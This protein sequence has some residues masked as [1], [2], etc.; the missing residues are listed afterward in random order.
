MAGRQVQGQSEGESDRDSREGKA[1]R[2]DI[3]EVSDGGRDGDSN[4]A[5]WNPNGK[6]YT[7]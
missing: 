2:G 1:R 6:G 3:T 7:E 4:N 5:L